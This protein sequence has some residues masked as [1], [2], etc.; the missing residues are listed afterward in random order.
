MFVHVL[1]LN[2]FYQRKTGKKKPVLILHGWGCSTQTMYCIF[3]YFANLDHDVVAIDFP[4]FGNSQTPPASFTIFDYAKVVDGVIREL[5]SCPPDVIAHSF[6]GRVALILA[7][8]NKINR[9]IITGGAGMKPRRSLKYH[10]K[11]ALHKL[12]KKVGL[13]T[14]NDGSADYRALTPNMKKVFVSVVNTHLENVL[15]KIKNPTLLIW[16]E[17]D[18]QTPLYMAKRMKRRI[19]DC[20]IVTLK[21]CSHFAFLEDTKTFLLVSKTFLEGDV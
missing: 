8:E 19:K 16:G 3:N 12:K 14:K 1:G 5:F 20:E 18:K 17:R 7:S 2:V 21:G 10:L 13:N 6:G 15:K 4:G 11:V 9:L